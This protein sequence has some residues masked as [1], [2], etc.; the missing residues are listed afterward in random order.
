MCSHVTPLSPPMFS[1]FFIFRH[2]L[3][4]LAITDMN[5]IGLNPIIPS[6][7]FPSGVFKKIRRIS[8]Q[9]SGAFVS[10]LYFSSRHFC[11]LQSVALGMHFVPFAP[12]CLPPTRRMQSHH[13]D[14]T[15]MP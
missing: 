5:A 15:P 9:D 4:R 3:H 2:Q 12:R 1:C 11:D 7:G 13:G 14:F 10:Y 8:L 6:S